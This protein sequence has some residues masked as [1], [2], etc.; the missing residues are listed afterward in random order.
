MMSMLADLSCCAGLRA[1]ERSTHSLVKVLA[2]M[3]R[4]LE[5]LLSLQQ[6]LPDVDVAT[7]VSKRLDLLLE[8]WSASLQSQPVQMLF[9]DHEVSACTA[10]VCL[11]RWSC[12]SRSSPFVQCM[13]RLGS[14]SQ[15]ALASR[16]DI[17]G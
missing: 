10:I 14:I 12:F 9:H 8:V 4:T 16:P 5:R 15:H 7:L 1:A 17:A 6:L 3:E 2:D 11:A 13:L